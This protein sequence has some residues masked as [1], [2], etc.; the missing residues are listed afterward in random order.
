MTGVNIKDQKT[1]CSTKKPRNLQHFHVGLY[2]P[3]SVVSTP[4]LH[5]TFYL[6]I[7]FFYALALLISVLSIC[8]HPALH[9]LCLA[10]NWFKYAS[11]E[12]DVSEVTKPWNGK[13]DVQLENVM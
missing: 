13:I 9:S 3:S 11:L 5:S 12:Q 8:E 2:P 6:C 4:P 10:I 1:H 7:V